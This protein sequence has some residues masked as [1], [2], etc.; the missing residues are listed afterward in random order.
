MTPFYQIFGARVTPGGAVM[1]PSGM[2]LGP[3]N[4]LFQYYPSV[5][6]GGTRFL[7]IWTYGTSP[8]Q[9]MGRFINTDGTLG[10]TIVVAIPGG[11]TMGTRLASDGANYFVAWMEYTGSEYA[12]R[13][14]VLDG[15]GVQ[16]CA[17][18]TVASGVTYN[19]LGLAYDGYNYIVTYSMMA[20]TAYQ[21][22]GRFLDASGTPL[23]TAFQISN[24]SY[25]CYYGDVFPGA[26]D[27][28]LNVWTES[29]STYD[30]YGNVDVE[31]GVEEGTV[32]RDPVIALKSTVVTNSIELRSYSAGK[33]VHI[34]D[35]SGCLVGAT[36]NGYYDCSKLGAGVYFVKM[37][38]DDNRCTK[39]LKIK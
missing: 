25:N 5:A 22:Y 9:I 35:A 21:I 24:S 18:F 20:G 27:R 7:A 1:E 26:N 8:Y 29:R 28:C 3:N 19:S 33:E 12:A 17:P 2:L 34:Y 37:A 15:S 39:V 36:R 6:F 31:I 30:I 14:V 16:I 4:T 38:L 11:Y 10:D 32:I 13:G 23:D